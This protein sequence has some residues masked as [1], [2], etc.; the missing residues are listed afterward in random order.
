M[1]FWTCCIV[2]TKPESLGNSIFQCPFLNFI[3]NEGC[4]TSRTARPM[5]HYL[6]TVVDRGVWHH[7]RSSRS[8]TV[9]LANLYQ[10]AVRGAMSMYRPVLRSEY[11]HIAIA[12]IMLG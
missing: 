2:F 5:Q 9:I 1:G 6:S 7:F 4:T 10:S 3:N 11:Y 8:L 12:T